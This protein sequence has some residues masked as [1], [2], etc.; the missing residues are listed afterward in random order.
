MAP[1]VGTDVLSPAFQQEQNSSLTLA[2]LTAQTCHAPADLLPMERPLFL[3]LY[4]I[5]L[6]TCVAG[7]SANLLVYWHR[8][9]RAA[10]TIRLLAAKAV[11][12]AL[13]VISLIPRFA[14]LLP[15]DL[16]HTAVENFYWKTLPVTLFLINLFGTVAIWLTVAVTV[17]SYIM[18]AFPAQAKSWCSIRNAYLCIV[19]C[20]GAAIALQVFYLLC[21]QVV[22][23]VCPNMKTYFYLLS[24]GLPA[25]EKLYYWANALSTL[26]IPMVTMLA[27]SLLI[28]YQL[29]WAKRRFSQGSEQKRCVTR[30]SMAT[31]AC[32]LV[33][34]MPHVVNF[35]IAAVDHTLARQWRRR[36]PWEQFA[37][38][39]NF[40]SM[41][42]ASLTVFVY[43]ACSQRFRQICYFTLCRS[44]HER[45]CNQLVLLQENKER[46]SWTENTDK[47]NPTCLQQR[48]S[49]NP[50]T[51]TACSV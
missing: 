45:Y 4:P 9:L 33:F 1:Q 20:F 16:K 30:L 24:T 36:F 49:N 32:H 23:V 31:T 48:T 40:L 19:G 18:V 6:L 38:V 7:N 17:E 35:I 22:P 37:A 39:A 44:R 47:L 5:I 51:Q 29:F 15:A 43:F 2:N 3:Y 14:H 26:L 25:Y 42:D 27:L 28:Y 10:P 41:L 21:R 46:Q 34:E 11:A 50:D 13:C 12:N 8:F